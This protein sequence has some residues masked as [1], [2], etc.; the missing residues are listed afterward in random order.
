MKGVRSRFIEG[1]ILQISDNTSF[2]KV[3]ARLQQGDGGGQLAEAVHPAETLF[4]AAV[5]PVTDWHF[6]CYQLVCGYFLLLL[7]AGLFFV[8]TVS[9]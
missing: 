6:E 9:K 3:L 5:S 8:A 2:L 1:N 4:Q 7:L